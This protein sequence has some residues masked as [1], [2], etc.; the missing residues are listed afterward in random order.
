MA[1]FRHATPGSIVTS[2][3]LIVSDAVTSDGDTKFTITQPVNSTVDAVIARNLDQIVFDNAS[4]VLKAKCGTAED[5]VEVCAFFNLLNGAT[6]L[7]ANKVASG[8]VENA[9][10]AVAGTM[11]T[12]ER[13][14]H[15]TLNANHTLTATGNG[16][17]EFTIAFRVFD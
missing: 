16:K 5:G 15:I 1:T 10:S 14:L 6:T 13:E 7:A 17:I 11:T 2:K 9:V 3:R 12:D 8:T 4:A